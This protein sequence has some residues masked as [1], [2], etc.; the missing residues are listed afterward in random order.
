MT[1]LQ[2]WFGLIGMGMV[3][4]FAVSVMPWLLGH[5]I[6]RPLRDYI[7][8]AL[9]VA[10]IARVFG[11]PANWLV[12]VASVV[13]VVVL[14]LVLSIPPL[15]TTTVV[16]IWWVGLAAFIVARILYDRRKRAVH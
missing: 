7:L 5:P 4:I 3:I 16:V 1:Q 11:P 6:P 13:G 9:F 8:G 10:G 12:D 14:M 2:R 15:N